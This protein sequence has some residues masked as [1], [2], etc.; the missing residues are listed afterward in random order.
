MLMN[1]LLKIEKIIILN[2][3]K[4]EKQRTWEPHCR[5]HST[6]LNKNTHNHECFL[7]LYRV[8]RE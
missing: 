4:K 6:I 7:L 5:F 8:K 3:S 2:N 1:K